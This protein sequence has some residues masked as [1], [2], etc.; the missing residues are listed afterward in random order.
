MPL[1]Y[2][3]LVPVR[4]RRR[5]VRFAHADPH[6]DRRQQKAIARLAHRQPAQR[7]ASPRAVPRP[8]TIRELQPDKKISQ[9]K[10]TYTGWSRK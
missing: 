9:Q 7:L 10:Q 6:E 4:F 5:Q 8:E 3:V 2:L 1:S